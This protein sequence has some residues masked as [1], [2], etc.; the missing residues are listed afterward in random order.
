[1]LNLPN[2]EYEYL[3]DKLEAVID[4]EPTGALVMSKVF[5]RIIPNYVRDEV[6]TQLYM[7]R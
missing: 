7:H 3:T 1:M 5:N 4:E 6:S 2:G